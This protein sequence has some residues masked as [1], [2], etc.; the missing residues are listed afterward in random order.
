MAIIEIQNARVDRI[1]FNDTAFVA[2]EEFK[3]SSGGT[4]EKKFT[5]WN[6]TPHGLSVGQRVTVRG[7]YGAKV[8]EFESDNDGTVRYVETS[9]NKPKITVLDGT[10]DSD[11][12]F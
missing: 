4:G 3:T 5:V 7:F 2:I 6:D 1:M 9:I 12:P 10:D 11:A 8:G